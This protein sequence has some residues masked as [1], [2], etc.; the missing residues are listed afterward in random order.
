M[1]K[2]DKSIFRDLSDID[3]FTILVD[4]ADNIAE[5]SF[6]I[7]KTIKLD[8]WLKKAYEEW[9]IAP[10]KKGKAH[11]PETSFRALSSINYKDDIESYINN[12]D[13]LWG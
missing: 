11:N 4:L 10:G 1:A 8:E 13:V 3:N 12:W 6:Y 9:V 2:K 5:I 7:I